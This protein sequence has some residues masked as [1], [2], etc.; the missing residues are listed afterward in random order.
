MQGCIK[1]TGNKNPV[2]FISTRKI[3]KTVPHQTESPP[4]GG[5]V[6]TGA[7]DLQPLAVKMRYK[8]MHVL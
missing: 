2:L 4:N 6:V 8:K 1:S 5:L 3:A 7:L